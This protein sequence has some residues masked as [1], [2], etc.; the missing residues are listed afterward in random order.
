[1]LDKFRNKASENRLEFRHI[2]V[3]LVVLVG[4]QILL[5][6]TQKS[7]LHDF[8]KRTQRWYKRDTAERIANLTTTS[9]EMLVENK[10]FEKSIHEN[11]KIA[12]IQSFNIILSQQ[13]LEQNVEQVCLLLEKN[14]QTY[15]IGDGTDLY[16]FLFSKKSLESRVDSAYFQ[17][18]EIYM[19][20]RDSLR[21]N[22]QIYTTLQDEKSFNILVPFT[23]HGEYVGALYMKNTLDL[24][25]LAGKFLSSYDEIAIIY[26]SLILLGLLT[27][28]YVSSFTLRER[29]FA[30]E[31]LFEEK[32]R[33]L[34]DQIVHQK[35]SLFTK[36][37]YHTHH[38]AEKIMGFIK[39]DLRELNTDNI[40]EIKFRA[41]K[42]ANFISRVIYDMKWYDPPI[43][44]IRGPMFRTNINELLK[45]IVTQIFERV[46]SKLEGIDFK[47]ELDENVPIVN[48]NEFVAW[49]IFE[50][51][52]QNAIDHGNKNELLIKI[53]TSYNP[54][55]KYSYV[56]IIDNGK[57]FA[58]NLLVPDE[59]G[60]KE[61]FKE[62]ITT[63]KIEPHSSGYGC[64]IAY[65]MAIK[66]C[67][68]EVDAVNNPD[69]GAKFIIKI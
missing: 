51:L 2:T 66:R 29:D 28:Y 54:D 33:Y 34:K 57:G 49:E 12:M 44:T 5:V 6:F 48:I 1:M 17:A 16:D 14:D 56:E 7:S 23:P 25:N 50:P 46:S 30:Q 35:E 52:I 3:L 40:E 45:F 53:K 11:E 38:K 41:T 32:E 68:W 63:K 19:K 61:I 58:S 67:R 13:T 62:H 60:V 20:F 65:E 18:S 43:Q 47:L 8:I 10:D 69:G 37:I 9:L 4:F 39:D 59:N 27:M 15:F 24:S 36:R 31:K 64:Y 55:E 22:E 21:I 26:T 42:Y